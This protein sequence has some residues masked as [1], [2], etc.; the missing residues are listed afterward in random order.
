MIFLAKLEGLR[1][2]W[3]VVRTKVNGQKNE[4]G[5]FI[6]DRSLS[7]ITVHFGSGPT[8]FAQFYGRSLGSLAPTTFDLIFIS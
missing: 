8:I 5:Q 1:S 7:F 2:R 4:S 6:K 3:A